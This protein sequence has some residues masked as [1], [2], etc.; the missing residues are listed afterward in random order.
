MSLPTNIKKI[1]TLFLILLAGFILGVGFSNKILPI[2]N[3]E[4]DIKHRDLFRA[5]MRMAV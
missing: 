3:K 4:I 2:F 1:F 5:T